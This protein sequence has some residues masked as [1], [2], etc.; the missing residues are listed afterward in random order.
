MGAN[1]I[2]EANITR[3]DD[4]CPSSTIGEYDGPSQINQYIINRKPVLQSHHASFAQSPTISFPSKPGKL[5]LES[6]PIIS[7][8]GLEPM[9][10]T[11][12]EIKLFGGEVKST[13]SSMNRSTSNN[14]IFENL[15]EPMTKTDKMNNLHPRVLQSIEKYPQPDPS[16]LHELDGLYSPLFAAEGPLEHRELRFT[17]FGQMKDIKAHG[18][19]KIIT[20]RGAL[21]EG[22][23]REGILEH[24]ARIFDVNGT[25]YFG[26][27]KDRV[28]HGHGTFIDKAEQKTEGKWVFG[29]ADG[30]V[31]VTNKN[32]VCIFKG[33]VINGAREG[34]GTFVNTALLY[35]YVG[36][37]SKDL[38][39]GQGKKTYQ[40]G[41]MYEGEFY[42]GQEHGNG[43]LHLIDGRVFHGRFEKGHPKGDG[44][45]ITDQGVS[46]PYI[47]PS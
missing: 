42:Q 27:F 29:K 32:G 15:Q 10:T 6:R 39:E 7:V 46:K 40:N 19:G 2:R 24:Y 21:I 38:Y 9:S 22:F 20:K 31:S 33:T 37:F 44:I 25:V 45:L 3:D 41:R 14:F 5:R 35:T 30:P 16:L 11:L 23:F 47:W 34:L 28:K 1:A 13:A 8:E 36:T 17:F 18:W 12:K 4:H 43:A 26:G